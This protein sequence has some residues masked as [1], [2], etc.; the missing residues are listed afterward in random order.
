M[1]FLTG[2]QCSN[3]GSLALN[4][5]FFVLGVLLQEE[6]QEQCECEVADEPVV[7]MK[8]RPK[9]AGNSLEDKTETTVNGGIIDF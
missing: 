9:K 1:V 4:P 6:T 2:S 3:W 5:D 8:F 7:V